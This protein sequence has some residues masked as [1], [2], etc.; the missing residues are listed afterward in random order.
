[1]PSVTYEYVYYPAGPHTRQPRAAGGL[2]AFELLK[3]IPGGD[4]AAG[5]QFI[6]PPPPATQVQ[7]TATFDFAFMNV[8]GGF[9]SA[10]GG[11]AVGATSTDVNQPSSPVYIQAA[12]II[13]LVV[14]IP[15]GGGPNGQHYGATI[16][17][18][19]ETTG[20][21]FNDTFVSVA[22]DTN[23][24]E[25][26]SGNVDGYADTTNSAETITALSRT[27]SGVLFD[28]WAMFGVNETVRVIPP[29]FFPRRPAQVIITAPGLEIDGLTLSVQKATSVSALAFYKAPPPPPPPP[30]PTQ[31]EIELANFNALEPKTNVGL[32]AYYRQL[33]SRCVGPQYTAAVVEIDALLKE[34]GA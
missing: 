30:P 15:V 27:S 16:D 25:T 18:F 33:L 12:P 28:Y 21:L 24:A 6:A 3:S 10:A 19:D 13:V 23:N 32:L 17:S 11:V 2:G 14:Y 9:S 20:T 8:S 22:P 31:C 4:Y 1:M 26:T 29:E 34:F 5:S 7:G